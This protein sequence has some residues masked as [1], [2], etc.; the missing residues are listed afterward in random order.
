[1]IHFDFKVSEAEAEIIFDG[2]TCQ[3]EKLQEIIQESLVKNSESLAAKTYQ[4]FVDKLLVLKTKMH[5][6]QINNG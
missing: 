5:N 1:M 4:P 2:I 6:R 3:I